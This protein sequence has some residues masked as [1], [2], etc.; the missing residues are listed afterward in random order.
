M[1]F[2]MDARTHAGTYPDALDGVTPVVA[3]PISVS[4][5]QAC[6]FVKR[7]NRNERS[8]LI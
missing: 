5:R 1:S 7:E 4:G 2:D 8:R 6:N 3:F